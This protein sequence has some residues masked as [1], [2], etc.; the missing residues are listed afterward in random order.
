MRLSL[1]QL[2]LLLAAALCSLLTPAQAHSY[3]T[4]YADSPDSPATAVITLFEHA[5]VVQWELN[6]TDAAPGSTL[7][8][9][10]VDGNPA[11][12]VANLVALAS[13]VPVD[14]VYG[15]AASSGAFDASG[16]D[17]SYQGMTVEEMESH[18]G[19]G[20]IYLQ[21]TTSD[22]ATLYGAFEEAAGGDSSSSSGG[23]EMRGSD[24]AHGGSMAAGVVQAA[25]GMA[26]SG[27]DHSSHSG[28]HH[29]RL[30]LLRRAA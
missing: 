10:I 8:A 25:D 23:T 13:G 3:Y 30:L 27:A 7:A 21:V 2:L 16:F 22:G 11:T 4:A 29:R 26:E 1:Q 20:H 14:A 24:T 15:S 5:G 18:M 19:M 28:G 9:A 17:A 12:S 6:V